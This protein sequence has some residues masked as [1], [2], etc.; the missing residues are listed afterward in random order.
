MKRILCVVCSPRGRAAESY[1]LSQR[2][3][4]FLRE[5]EPDSIVIERMIGWRNIEHV[6]EAYAI[7]QQ[8][9]ADLAQGGS[10][11]QSDELIRE[12]ESADVLVIATPMHNLT[13]PSALKAWIDHVVRVRRTFNVTPD[14]KVG[15]LRDRPVFVAVASG[16]KFSGERARQPDFLTPYLTAILGMVGLCD[17]A[18]FSIQGTGAG[19]QAIAEA[20]ARTDQ[21]LREHFASLLP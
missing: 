15:L 4:G 14:G 10:F 9:S 16:G 12:L 21:A 5:R 19:R 18:F 1:R 13:V 11:S 17:L 8:S 6:D 20:R 3:I 2:I 7:A